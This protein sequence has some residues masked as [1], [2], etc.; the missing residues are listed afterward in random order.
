[1]KKI[2]F[3]LSCMFICAQIFGQVKTSGIVEYQ[4]TRK[5]N[6]QM[7]GEN[8][9]M[10]KLIPQS[11]STK[12]ALFFNQGES[13]YTNQGYQNSKDVEEKKGES[14]MKLSFRVPK[15]EIHTDLK[16][17]K[18]NQSVELM[19]KAFLVADD[20]KSYKWQITAEQKIILGYT[21]Q[22]AIDQDTSTGVSVWFTP[23]IPISTGPNGLNG[24]PGLILAVENAKENKMTLASS[25]GDLPE[26]YEFKVPSEGKKVS[27]AE[28]EKTR[29]EKMKEAGVTGKGPRII[30]TT[31]TKVGNQ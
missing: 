19:G 17:K 20:A 25:V 30:M 18:V 3:L 29:E 7:G 28:Y 13:F 16:A 8:P 10:A 22:K 6:L 11:M 21:C 23:K 31:D 12:A 2:S 5:L 24:L 15:N 14:T 4:E 1:M 27:R 9:D 26:G